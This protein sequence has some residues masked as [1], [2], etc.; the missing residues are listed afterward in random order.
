VLAETLNTAQS[1]NQRTVHCDC[2]S[3]TCIEPMLTTRAQDTDTIE[4]G[5]RNL[6]DKFDAS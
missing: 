5:P 2:E 3:S 4:N 1:I 6:H